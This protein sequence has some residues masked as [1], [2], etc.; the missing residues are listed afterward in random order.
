MLFTP[1]NRAYQYLD[2]VWRIGNVAMTGNRIAAL[3]GRGTD[4]HRG[5]AVP[6]PQHGRASRCAR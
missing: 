5:R 2:D 4:L 6:R 1:N 3:A